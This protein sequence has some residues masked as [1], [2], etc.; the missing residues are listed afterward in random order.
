MQ[1]LLWRCEAC[2]RQN[3]VTSAKCRYC[4]CESSDD[5]D[6]DYRPRLKWQLRQRSAAAGA[7]AAIAGFSEAE[8]YT[9][10]ETFTEVETGKGADALERR[11]SWPPPSRPPGRSKVR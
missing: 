5:D 11:P 6:D 10:V 4:V 2:G 3:A 1:T 7:R 8:G 9:V